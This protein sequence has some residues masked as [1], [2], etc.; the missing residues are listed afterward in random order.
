MRAA[1]GTS[2]TSDRR[3]SRC[4]QTVCALVLQ[5]LEFSHCCEDEVEADRLDLDTT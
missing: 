1:R 4:L 5:V 3:L 2:C